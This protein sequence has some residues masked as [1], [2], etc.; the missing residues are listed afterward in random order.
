MGTGQRIVTYRLSDESK[1]DV[2]GDK[3]RKIIEMR[4]G[5]NGYKP[6]W[7]EHVAEHFDKCMQTI[8]V[9][10]RRAWKKLRDAGCEIEL[11]YG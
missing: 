1:L 6:H 2:L 7:L 5:L 10:E 4:V 8:W 9:I 3:E 11:V